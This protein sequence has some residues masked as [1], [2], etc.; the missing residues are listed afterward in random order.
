MRL[1]LI[2]DSYPPEMRNA[3]GRMMKELGHSL[4]EL[5]HEV[6][7]ATPSPSISDRFEVAHDG[8][9]SVLRARSQR[10]K[11]QGHFVRGVAELGFPWA[12]YHSLKK[13]DWMRGPIDGIIWYSPSIFFGPLVAWLKWR[14]RAKAYLILR[15][16]FP[17]WAIETG[18]I[19]SGLVA[20][21]LR[22]IAEL[23][24]WVADTIGIQ[25]AHDATYLSHIPN[26]KLQ[27]LSNWV[28]TSSE[29]A[30]PPDWMQEAW[31]NEAEIVVM[32][33]ALG[34]AQDPDNILRLAER[35]QSR[36]QCILLCV[37]DGDRYAFQAEAEK[38]GLKNIVI[39]P[40][41][42]RPEF[43]YLL[44]HASLGLISLHPDL[45]TQNVPGRLLSHLH[46]GLPTIASLNSNSQLFELFK[47]S[48]CGIAVE[49][50]DDEG[51]YQAVV[52]LLDHPEQREFL[53]NNAKHLAQ[54]FQP[55]E[56]ARTITNRL[57]SVKT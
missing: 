34:P 49:N 6:L 25:A 35:L 10:A 55:D 33:G 9:L 4:A 39:K 51:F 2:V 21:V 16:I 11:G 5:G 46:A 56:A 50:G 42:A 36:D 27:V 14:Y 17:D 47:E 12:L 31:F 13:I 52:Q 53:G 44:R 18:S 19:Q 32:G 24:Y 20:R 30:L 1:L 40:S 22:L 28:G 37:G 15:D 43:D 48:K 3:A 57:S 54:M 8:K 38:R 26:E 45:R 23:Q 7:I 29:T 41:L